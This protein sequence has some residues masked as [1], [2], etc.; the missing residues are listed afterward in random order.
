METP[1]IAIAW[2]FRDSI[3]FKPQLVTGEFLIAFAAMVIF[4][5]NQSHCFQIVLSIISERSSSVKKG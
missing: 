1:S 3:Q 4:A 5:N 2:L